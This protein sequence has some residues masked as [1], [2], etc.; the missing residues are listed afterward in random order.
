[1][2]ILNKDTGK[3]ILEVKGDTLSGVNL[4]GPYADLSHAYPRNTDLSNIDLRN[5][6]LYCAD[7]RKVDLSNEHLHWTDLHRTK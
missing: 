7:L 4:S 6:D 1:M 2:K 5:A 3:V